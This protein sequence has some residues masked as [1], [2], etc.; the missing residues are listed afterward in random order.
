VSLTISKSASC[1]TSKN[2]WLALLKNTTSTGLV[3][4]EIFHDVRTAIAREKQI[5]G[6]RREKR[7]ALIE[8][9]NPKWVDLHFDL[10]DSD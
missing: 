1:S 6:W 8:S 5:K 9:K 7:V 2:W 3:R 10:L 4:F